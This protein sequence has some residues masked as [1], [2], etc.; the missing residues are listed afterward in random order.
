MGSQ[1]WG[2]GGKLSKTQAANELAKYQGGLFPAP[3]ADLAWQVRAWGS[4]VL[5]QS[6]KDLERFYPSID[7]GAIAPMPP[8]MR[9]HWTF[10]SRITL[11]LDVRQD[12]QLHR[13]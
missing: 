7:G 4:W 9:P 5:Q 6:R 2:G 8:I 13:A 11:S 3:E 12:S 1:R 10:F